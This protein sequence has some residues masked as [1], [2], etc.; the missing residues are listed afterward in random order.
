[1]NVFAKRL[2]SGRWM[3]IAVHR[4]VRIIGV[5]ATA[6]DA[7]RDAVSRAAWNAGRY[8]DSHLIG[9]AVRHA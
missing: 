6:R 8:A 5:G 7:R 9:L 2:P 1:M 4:G 3:G